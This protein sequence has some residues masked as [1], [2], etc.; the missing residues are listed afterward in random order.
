MKN[1]AAALLCEIRFESVQNLCTNP[2][3]PWQL[4]VHMCTYPSLHSSV[5]VPRTFTVT[6]FGSYRLLKT[7]A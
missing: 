3:L 6:N 1:N 4:L 2:M 7:F 5:F